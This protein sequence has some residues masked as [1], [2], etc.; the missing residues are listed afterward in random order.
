MERAWRDTSRGGAV[1]GLL[2]GMVGG[3]V[4]SG[5]ALTDSVRKEE[6]ISAWGWAALFAGTSLMAAWSVWRMM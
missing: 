6:E 1:L 5:W 2:V 3:A 4:V